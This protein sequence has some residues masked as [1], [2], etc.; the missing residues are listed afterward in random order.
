MRSYSL[1]SITALAIVSLVSICPSTLLRNAG[2]QNATSS[3][4][5][6]T[7]TYAI[8]NARIV[9]VSGPTIERGT[10]VIRNGLIAA[11]GESVTAPAV[12]C[13][14]CSSEAARF[15]LLVV[16]RSFYETFK[17]RAAGKQ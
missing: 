8:T 4:N 11:V 15:R 12:M 1:K 13:V 6:G 7:D 10:I 5:T 2:A 14:T 9:T 16:T 3:R 17:D